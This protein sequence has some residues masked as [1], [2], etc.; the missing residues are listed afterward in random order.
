[1]YCALCTLDVIVH[2]C[3]C[4]VCSVVYRLCTLCDVCTLDATCAWCLLCSWTWPILACC[5]VNL[6]HICS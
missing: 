5:M 6:H 4:V 3:V 2:A 1:M